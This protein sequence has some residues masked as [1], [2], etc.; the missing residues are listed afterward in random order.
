MMTIPHTTLIILKVLLVNLLLKKDMNM[1]RPRNHIQEAEFTPRIKGRHCDPVSY[2]HLDVYKR[3][4]L[5]T[6]MAEILLKTREQ[7]Y[8]VIWTVYPLIMMRL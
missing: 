3:Q 8:F 4:V 2:T 5:H 6:E 1:E 7:K